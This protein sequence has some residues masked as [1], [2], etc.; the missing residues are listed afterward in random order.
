MDNLPNWTQLVINFNDARNAVLLAVIEGR[1][2]PDDAS[3]IREEQR[4]RLDE[5]I[6]DTVNDT[7]EWF[8]AA[9]NKMKEREI[10]AE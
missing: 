1:L 8:L 4:R 9:A 3:L 6:D 7:A 2:N 5:T 10:H